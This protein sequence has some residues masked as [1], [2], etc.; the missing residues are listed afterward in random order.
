MYYGCP[1]QTGTPVRKRFYIWGWLETSM[2]P[3]IEINHHSHILK[4]INLNDELK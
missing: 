3:S 2:E 4:P 1:Q